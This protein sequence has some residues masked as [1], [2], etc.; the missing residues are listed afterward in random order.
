[1]MRAT[2][3]L[4]LWVAL[5]SAGRGGDKKHLF[6]IH[7]AP[8]VNPESVQIHYFMT[9]D[10]GGHDGF[11]VET[12]DQ[13]IAIRLDQTSKPPKSLKAVLYAPGCEIDLIRADDLRNGDHEAQFACRPLPALDISAAFPRPAALNP[14]QLDVEVN[15]IAPWSHEFFGVGDGA[16]MT[17]LIASVTAGRDGSFRLHLP[18]FSKDPLY[19]TVGKNAELHFYVRE[20]SS[21][22]VVAELKGPDSLMSP[23][24]GM[25]I[26]GN[27][28]VP[29]T[30]M[31]V[32]SR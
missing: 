7:V 24:G 5:A 25:R 22:N 30:F 12:H 11:Q 15:Y 8:P 17:I 6:L 2:A 32:A 27:Y 13:E 3:L 23:S 28:P 19:G 31:F 4:F 20:R 29:L 14:Y 21:G 26:E 1:M 10:F 16:A 18:D 9:G